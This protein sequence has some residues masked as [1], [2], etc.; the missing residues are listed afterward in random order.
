MPL[1]KIIYTIEYME[2]IWLFLGN[3][4]TWV[5]LDGAYLSFVSL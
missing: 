4:Y 1:L 3:S 2:F 5:L